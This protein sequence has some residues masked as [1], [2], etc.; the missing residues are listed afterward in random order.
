MHRAARVIPKDHVKSR[1]PKRSLFSQEAKAQK[2]SPSFSK[3]GFLK[4]KKLKVDIPS[5]FPTRYTFQ[6]EKEKKKRIAL[7]TQQSFDVLQWFYEFGHLP[8]EPVNIK[9]AERESPKEFEKF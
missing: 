4:G 9:A 2:K 7:K 6:S 5:L 3:F 1:D 8:P